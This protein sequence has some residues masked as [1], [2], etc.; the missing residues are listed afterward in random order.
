MRLLINQMQS[1][2]IKLEFKCVKMSVV[3]TDR[4]LLFP[5]VPSVVTTDV[6]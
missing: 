5:T 2:F 3:T 1:L 6:K 4:T